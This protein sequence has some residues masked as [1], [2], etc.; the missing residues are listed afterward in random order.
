MS[1]IDLRDVQAALNKYFRADI[2]RLYTPYKEI[3]R[4]IV[5]IEAGE[6]ELNVTYLMQLLAQRQEAER[7]LA[8]SLLNFL[9]FTDWSRPEYEYDR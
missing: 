6:E 1:T 8:Q 9:Y 5:K 3:E 4:H 2:E 7:K